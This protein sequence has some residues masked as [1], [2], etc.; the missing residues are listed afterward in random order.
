M[1]K[2]KAWKDL[3]KKWAEILCKYGL[4]AHRVSRAGNYSVSDYDVKVEELPFLKSDTK[5]SQA[6][7]KTNRL[8][9]ETEE[10]YCKEKLDFAAI[11]TKGYKEQGQ[12]VCVDSEFMAMLLAFWAGVATKEELIST[13]LGKK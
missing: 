10:K 3:E 6:G 2:S 4:K 11:V 9:H 7:F 1:A 5:Y 8:M 13:Y 12:D